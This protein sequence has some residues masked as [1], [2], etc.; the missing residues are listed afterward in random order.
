[1]RSIVNKQIYEQAI[2]KCLSSYMLERW[3]HMFHS[4]MHIHILD[5][6]RFVTK[7]AS[8][9]SAMGDLANLV[10]SLFESRSFDSHVS[11]L[12]FTQMCYRFHSVTPVKFKSFEDSG[13][14]KLA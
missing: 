11:I 7:L 9:T 3:Q 5:C 4:N 13:L 8:M 2:S 10:Q 12:R 14:E 6:T 1:V